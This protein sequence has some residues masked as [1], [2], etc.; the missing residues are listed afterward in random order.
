MLDPD[1]ASRFLDF[2]LDDELGDMQASVHEVGDR[3][4]HYRLEELLGEGGFGAVWRASQL[5]PIQREVA[6]KI[7]RGDLDSAPVIARFRTERQALGQMEHNNI[8]RMYEA[9]ASPLGELYFAMELVRGV[10]IT[11]YCEAKK[12]S[13]KQRVDLFIQVCRG[14]EHAHLKAVLH[15]D[16][17]P[18]N[19]L[20]TEID[21]KP[22]A[23]I[24]D[25]GIAKALS[26]DDSTGGSAALTQRGLVIGSF[27]YMSPEQA[28]PGADSNDIR[29]DV[30]ALGVVLYELLTGVTPLRSM[31]DN[32]PTPPVAAMLGWIVET[33]PR[34]PS[35][36][37]AKR[38]QVG[39]FVPTGVSRR[40]ASALDW[41]VL[42]ALE[43]EAGNRY[44]TAGALA[45]ELGNYLAD[46]PL[47]VGTPS[48]ATR[49]VRVAS[50]YRTAFALVAIGAVFAIVASLV[51]GWAYL[52]ESRQ[53][54]IA[55]NMQFH[56]E[57]S[58]ILARQES[59]RATSATNFLASVLG[60]A[61]QQVSEGK[62]AEAL[63]AGLKR[64]E[65]LV[66]KLKGQEFLQAELYGRLAKAYESMDDIGKALPLRQKEVD[67][68]SKL[69]RADD[70]RLLES[71]NKL[72]SDYVNTAKHELALKVYRTVA[73][74][75][76]AARKA[77][78]STWFEARVQEGQTLLVLGQKKEALTCFRALLNR[79]TGKHFGHEDPGFL[80]KLATAEGSAGERE[81]SKA[82]LERCLNLR[83]D[84]SK[85]KSKGLS[86]SRQASIKETLARIERTEGH[87]LE[88]ARLL[89][90]S[91]ALYVEDRGPTHPSLIDTWVEAARCYGSIKQFDVALDH[92]A[93]GEVIAIT[94]GI[95]SQKVHCQRARSEL[96]TSAGRDAEALAAYQK[97]L[98]M[99]DASN[100]NRP[101][102]HVDVRGIM[103]TLY[104]K[105]G[106]HAEAMTLA[107]DVWGRLSTTRSLDQDTDLW[108][109]TL[110][111]LLVAA[112]AAA[113][114][115]PKLPGLEKRAEWQMN[116]DR[117]QK[118][119]PAQPALPVP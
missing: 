18:G 47:S 66:A 9:G 24:I 107:T 8:A 49:M 25:F 11:E 23:K 111:R 93:K 10:P 15:R 46:L 103:V 70:P 37:L 1:K 34:R 85:G 35:V 105:V 29:V 119:K 104:S 22:V 94:D 27:D 115:D 3:V 4:G 38:S 74:R 45:D 5:E 20:V 96:L 21:G 33:P 64:G 16:L 117:L 32:G 59:A 57:A 58:E 40:A 69:Q 54:A 81:A 83:V 90:E 113:K 92:V 36:E 108:E 41:V 89:D 75:C 55:E 19:I 30:Y 71:M 50:R 118:P 26:N 12:L 28:K 100:D 61:G 106:Q 56:A 112:D 101:S 114:A 17:K 43:K 53:R 44:S 98:P 39:T 91:I 52:S 86:S 99:L 48:L 84:M 65:V 95:D 14:V 2:A 6:L 72:A 102:L 97:F 68:L 31:M 63:R 76:E 62:N 60:E 80:M 82:T 110:K 88:A 7:V 73:E 87:F 42:K 67:M 116:L 13:L 109:S 77:D 79:H 51:S 78:T